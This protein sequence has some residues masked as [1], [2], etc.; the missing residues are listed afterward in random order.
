MAHTNKYCTYS[1]IDP[2][3]ADLADKVTKQITSHITRITIITNGEFDRHRYFW[4]LFCRN[5]QRLEFEQAWKAKA[6]EKIDALPHRNV[7]KSLGLQEQVDKA[8]KETVR[9]QVKEFAHQINERVADF[10]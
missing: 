3:E 8:F 1:P 9:E 2:S 10:Q 6:M 4:N 5:E 7:R